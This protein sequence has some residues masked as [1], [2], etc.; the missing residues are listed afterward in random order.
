MHKMEV[1]MNFTRL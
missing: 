1:Y